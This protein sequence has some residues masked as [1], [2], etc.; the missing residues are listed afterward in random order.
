MS[1]NQHATPGSHYARISATAKNSTSALSRTDSDAT[2]NDSNRAVSSWNASS[3]YL[4]RNSPT[5]RRTG[6]YQSQYGLSEKW[7]IPKWC[8]VFSSFSVFVYGSAALICALLTWFR[9]WRLA[10]VMLIADND[11]MVL[12]TIAG[13]ITM[14]TALTGM[15]GTMLNSRPLLAV[16]AVLLWSTLIAIFIVGR[17]SYRR[18]TFALDR[19][20]NLAW[21]RYYTALGRLLIQDTLQC[22]GYYTPQHEVTLS[23]SCHPNAVLP[24]CKTGLYAFEQENLKLVW[25]MAL[26]LV[27]LHVVNIVVGLLCANHV[28]VP[29]I[30]SK[31]RPD[32]GLDTEETQGLLR[33]TKFVQR[34]SISRASSSGIFREDRR[35]FSIDIV[36]S[37]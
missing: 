1:E 18:S 24:G 16:Y 2:L 20:L 29:R 32:D 7:T 23:D 4:A 22:C 28:T 25:T 15:I 17:I 37:V 34:P 19:K 30:L 36:H 31:R 27:P 10:S 21:S 13:S 5:P 8:L 6:H 35:K 26:S 12:I 9:T 3:H 14:L 11:V 33:D